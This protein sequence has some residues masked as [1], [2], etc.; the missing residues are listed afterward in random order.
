MEGVRVTPPGLLP[1]GAGDDRGGAAGRL[2]RTLR[3]ID[4]REQPAATTADGQ[5]QCRVLT[6]YPYPWT[7]AGRSRWHARC[8]AA[9]AE[10]WMH[11]D[12]G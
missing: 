10:S 7:S 11:R 6:E 12:P 8:S 9:E 1:G 4:A 2:S 5:R 3:S